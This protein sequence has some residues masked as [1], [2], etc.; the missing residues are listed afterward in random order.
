MARG[1][2]DVASACMSAGVF[3][4]LEGLLLMF[5]SRLDQQFKKHGGD[6]IFPQLDDLSRGRRHAAKI[7]H[8]SPGL[9]PVR[10][11]QLPHAACPVALDDSRQIDRRKVE[12]ALADSAAA[13]SES[14]LTNLW[15]D[16]SAVKNAMSDH[17]LVLYPGILVSF[18]VPRHYE[19]AA[20]DEVIARIKRDIEKSV[21]RHLPAGCVAELQKMA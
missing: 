11:F 13:E 15:G 1:F 20:F 10:R 12:N 21:E 4:M 7:A 18:R 8:L 5:C 2:D 17:D 19:A 9:A 14:G 3:Q 16:G 6:G